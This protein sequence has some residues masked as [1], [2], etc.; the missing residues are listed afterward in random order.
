MQLKRVEKYKTKL[1]ETTQ[2]AKDLKVQPGYTCCK[3][4]CLQANTHRAAC[5]QMLTVLLVSRKSGTSCR[6]TTTS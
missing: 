2:V 5:E 1:A 3:L 4:R 6:P